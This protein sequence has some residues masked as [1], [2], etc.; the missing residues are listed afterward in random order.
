MLTGAEVALRPYSSDLSDAR[1]ELIEPVLTAWRYERH[2]RAL[3]FG[4]LGGF[5]KAGGPGMFSLTDSDRIRDL[6]AAGGFDE[7][8]VQRVE[9]AGMWGAD[10]ADASAF[11]LDSGREAREFV[12]PSTP[13]SMDLPRPHRL[14]R[15]RTG[16]L[17]GKV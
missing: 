1:W 11:L 10:S 15:G 17:T 16:A 8:E 13:Y 5:G 7:V 12:N 6:L 2:G 14:F 4:P 3:G 9:A